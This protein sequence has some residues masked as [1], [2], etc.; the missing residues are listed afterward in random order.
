MEHVTVDSITAITACCYAH[1][2]VF[3]KT[4]FLVPPPETDLI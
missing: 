3:V 4:N 2:T 1:R